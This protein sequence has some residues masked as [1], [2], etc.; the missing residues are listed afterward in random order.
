MA[1]P[2]AL[3]ENKMGTQ[4]I[5][6]L[7][8]AMALPI[9]GSMIIQALYNI[10]DSIFV[11]WINENALSAVSLAFPVQN[12][13][14]SL[15]IGTATGVNALVSRAL[16]SK[17]TK[18]ANT[19]TQHAV[20]LAAAIYVCMVII[21]L[22]IITPYMTAM[23][24]DADPQIRE[25]GI[26]YLNIVCIAGF[27]G[28]FCA[29]FERLLNSTGK[30]HLPPISQI[31]GAVF[32]IIL[33]PVLIFGYGPFP[34]MGVAGAALATVLGQ[35]LGAGIA[36]M[37]NIKKNKEISLNMKGFRPQGEVIKE[38]YRIAAPSIVMMLLL[39]ITNVVINKILIGFTETAVAVF[40]VFHKLNS[41]VFFPIFGLNQAVVPLFSYN[42]GAKNKKRMIQTIRTALFCG[43]FLMCVGT[44][45]FLI[46][47][48]QLMLLFNASEAML[49]IGVLAMRIL[50][51]IFPVA[52]VS[53]ILSSIMQA[54][55]YALYSMLGA[56]LR[57]MV[58]LVP[59]AY[60]FARI[61]GLSAIWWA[62]LAAEA[63]SLTAVLLFFRKVY[64]AVVVPLPDA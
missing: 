20:F 61:G 59:C 30:T 56:I 10:V 9:T 55:S 25:Y 5:A 38:I 34:E 52:A 60:L 63:I 7:L 62:Y 36:L 35:T 8:I 47:P 28:P 21:S 51:L 42:L 23:V 14:I 16:G 45:I 1:E 48:R 22:F 12:I 6:R 39:S 18:K 53:I 26:T 46:F 58:V 33:D 2:T 27:G 49:S 54:C 50:C 19:V 57:Q 15:G 43:V 4:P 41:F 17:D 40:G 11:S 3:K 29:M 32:N 37:L 64:N 31:C 24:G 44:A 13:Y